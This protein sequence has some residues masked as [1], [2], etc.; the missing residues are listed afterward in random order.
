[1]RVR[2]LGAIEICDAQ[3]AAHPVG[4]PNQRVVLAALVA[5]LGQAVSADA[6]IDALWD[7][8][9][10]S[11]LTSLRTYISRLRHH[12]GESLA[13]RGG[14]WSLEVPP[15]GVDAGRFEELVRAATSARSDDAVKLL[16]DALALWHGPAFAELADLAI[17]RAE[18]RRLE[19]LKS[20]A[21]ESRAHHLLA[22]GAVDRAAAAAEALVVDE[23]LR[24]GGWATLVRAL[25]AASQPAEALRAYQRAVAA[26]AEAGLEPC[27][28][29]RD[30]E[31]EVLSGESAFS[32]ARTTI[33]RVSEV[34][35]PVHYASTFVGRDL[36]RLRV[37]QLLERARVVTLVGPGGVGKTRLAMEL[38]RSLVDDES[39]DARVVELGSVQDAPSVAAT[40]VSALG[41]SVEGQSVTDALRRAGELDVVLVLDNAEHVIDECADTVR[42]LV[43]GG[44]ALRVLTTSRERLAI[45][46]EHVWTVAPLATEDPRGPAVDLFIDRALAAYPTLDTDRIAEVAA[47]IVRRLDGLPLGIEMAAAQ[48]STVDLDELQ[49]ILDE[50]LDS[51]RSPNR[52]TSERHRSLEALLQ[53]SEA[54]LDDEDAHTW[55]A[56]SVF[57]GSVTL[58]DITGVLGAASAG[59]VR[60]LAERSLVSIDRGQSPARFRLL[61]TVRTH[62]AARLV[63]RGT[64]ERFRLEHARWFTHVAEQADAKLRTIDEADAVHTFETS[65]AEMRA[66]HRWSRHADP[67]LAAALSSHLHLYAQSRLIDEPLQ[68]AEALLDARGDEGPC[69][70][71]LL[72]SAATRAANGGNLARARTLAERALVRAGTTRAALPALEAITDTSLYE[73]RLDDAIAA[74]RRLADLADGHGDTHYATVG[75]INTAVGSSYRGDA[76]VEDEVAMLDS[77]DSP[78]HSPTSRGWV[79]YAIGECLLDRAPHRALEQLELAVSFARLVRNPFLEG[80]ALVSSCSLRARVGETDDALDAF[81]AVIRHWMRLANHTHL[82]TTLRNLTTLFMRIGAPSDA[83]ELLGSC[84]RDD[85]PTYGHEA[86]Q[87]DA[88]RA[89]ARTQLG[90]EVFERRRAEGA[91]RS[92][93]DASRWV[94]ERIDDATRRARI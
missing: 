18:A 71:A 53:W 81:G 93:P 11:A 80:V 56:L 60:T 66:A 6:L 85:V 46:G 75:R 34:T 50:R 2:V 38:A 51:L 26:L 1:M 65:F 69:G 55:A 78:N 77:F 94:L 8:P 58:D 54:L 20:A 59:R 57:A 13:S 47:S 43:G 19:V 74:A 16:D 12:F 40:V 87:L 24:E 3:G 67:D 48:L 42:H 27:A 73:G 32:A 86:E 29:L 82:L 5:R 41:L 7:D 72:A 28:A 37:R 61:E 14:G 89:W 21:A 79:A 91:R 39:V 17:V 45:D 9:P 64:A 76:D 63:Q 84:E 10:P 35:R 70:A 52:A 49:S 44:R 90:P 4:S 23:P 30:A 92:L 88:V 22:S 25:A 83:A 15:S 36:D 62:A 33:T 68:W 31:R